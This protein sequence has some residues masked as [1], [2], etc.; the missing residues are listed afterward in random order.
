L[1]AVVPLRLTLNLKILAAAPAMRHA[2]PAG[3][4][5][6]ASI[7]AKKVVA[8]VFVQRIQPPNL[9]DHISQELSQKLLPSPAQVP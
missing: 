2:Q 9:K 8:V 3:T 5:A 6:P 7:A 1:P 4:A